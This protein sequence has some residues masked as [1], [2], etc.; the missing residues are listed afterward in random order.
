MNRSALAPPGFA[1]IA[2]GLIASYFV[3][4][5]ERWGEWAI[6]ASFGAAA[7]AIAA[8]IV[9]YRPV[10]PAPWFTLAV[11]L[12]VAAVASAIGSA[13]HFDGDTDFPGLG[14]AVG[15]LAYPALFVGVIGV[16]SSVRG[17][18]DLLAGTEPIIYAIAATSLVWL[19]VIE[20][21]ID[22]RDL[23]VPASGWIWL[24]TLFD[25]VLAG[26]AA[27]RAQIST[28][29]RAVFTLLA[30]AFLAAGIAHAL[31]GWAR[32]HGTYEPG[33]LV[34]ASVMLA[35]LLIGV[36]TSMPSMAACPSGAD[37]AYP[38]R[39]SN[40]LGLTVAALVPLGVLILVLTTGAG[41]VSHASIVFVSASTIAV[42]VLSIARMWGL[43][44]QVRE[45]TERRGQDRLAAMVEHS[46]D[47]VMLADE[48]GTV[49]Y[50]SPGLHGTLGYHP[51]RWVG[52]SIVDVVA[53]G[54]R[55]GALQQLERLVASASGGTVEFETTLVRADGHQRRASVVMANL[56]GGAAVDGVV[57]T[58][59]DITEQRKLERQLSHRAFHDELTGLANRAL[60]LDRMDHALRV[61]RSDA[62]PVVVLFVDLDDFK[63]VNDALGHG[64]GDQTLKA[65]ADRIRRSAGSGDTAARL[66]G[67]EFA[68][69][70][71]DRG[72]I[73]RAIDVAERLLD[74]LRLPVSVSGYDVTVLASIGVAVATSGMS[75]T[76]LLRDAD[77]AMYEAKRAGKG[78]IRIFDPAMRMVATRQLEYRSELGA[79]VEQG[80]LRLVFMPFV[81]LRTGEVRGAEALV[82]WH[83]PEHGDIPP[84]EFVPIAE[85]SGLIVPIGHWVL[86]EGLRQ[87]AS[88]RPDAGLFLSVNVS[89][90]QL[91]Q[92]DFVDRIVA[93][94]ASHHLD[95]R[96]LM[97]E[98]TESVLVEENDRATETIERLRATGVRLAIDDFGAGY[99]SLS[100]LQRHPVDMIKIDRA[101]IEELGRDPRGSTLARTILQMA[102]S[103]ELR[104]VAEG[105]ETT[106]QL[107]E[108][109]RL[110]CDLGQG[111][112]LS[113]PLEAAALSQRFGSETDAVATRR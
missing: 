20:P 50:A 107:R 35:P 32:Y 51:D 46:N 98:V 30:V 44:V 1:V 103:L 99:C 112:L 83:H 105:I 70:L 23:P 101:F 79:A 111:Y 56:L 89:P 11:G 84:T 29:C 75:T 81:D 48:H 68:I 53:D 7:V 62:D 71:E 9:R 85:R 18:R 26:I 76:S 22:G 67:D 87:A 95:P 92:A 27:R 65:I 15:A 24:F 19:A 66:G 97:V 77:I 88:W 10:R 57:A 42:V 90:V 12:A 3:A 113:R 86:E 14:E 43:V 108:L 69:L 36:A 59:R 49:S 55:A 33:G 40:V 4:G 96:S 106:G 104:T 102:D 52:R 34:A 61:T 25:V 21:Y 64:V 39:W 74:S 38:I 13:H 47:V 60:F 93:A 31:V 91:R 72:G 73:D 41:D 28:V 16:T 2:A 6:V 100:Y 82:R 37:D 94:V 17:V 109:R 80:Q 5:G 45:L 58:F 78:Q 8:S 110:G 63:A 54:E